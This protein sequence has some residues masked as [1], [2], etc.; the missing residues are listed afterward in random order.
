MVMA[1]ATGTRDAKGADTE[2]SEE[3]GTKEPAMDDM[4][5]AP[6]EGSWVDVE[7]RW[8]RM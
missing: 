1:A 5:E 4:I 2:E 7:E 3:V 8:V 6:P